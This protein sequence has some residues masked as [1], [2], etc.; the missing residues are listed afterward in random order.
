MRT[1][2]NYYTIGIFVTIG[3][4]LVLGF[5][6]ILGAGAI[7][8][9]RVLIETYV[10][11]SI[12]GI[13]VGSHVKM[14]GV[15]IGNVEH[16][17]FVNIKYPEALLTEKR[18]VLLEISL[19]LKAFGDVTPEELET[20]LEQEAKK[21]LRVRML[22]MGITGS[23][24]IEIDYL[25]PVR[26]PPLP[27]NWSPENTYVPSA[28]GTFTRLEETFESLSNTMAKLE[29]VDFRSTLD[30]LD[31]LIVSLTATVKSLDLDHMTTQANLFMDE[32][33]ETNLRISGILGPSSQ[34]MAQDIN[35]YNILSDTSHVMGD[36]R[37]GFERLGMDQEDGTLDQLFQTIANLSQA[38]EDLPRTM[39]SIR[40]AAD[41]M[42]QGSAG[43]N[44]MTRRAHSLMA[45]Q[46]Q[47]IEAI[48]RDMEVTTRNL[49]D[50]TTDA[51]RYPSY[52]L[53]GD[54]P[55]ESDPR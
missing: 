18:Y 14:R 34:Q 36:I 15:Q 21:G 19:S 28:P 39:Q 50:L 49:M 1:S 20:F 42:H 12:Q 52:F 9:E 11:E 45:S 35:I 23:S 4:I 3:L 43:F 24:Y 51:R 53:F 55:L 22:P 29:Q 33:R 37:K 13:D 6:I 25:D 27:I 10:D 46:N 30:H 8:R 44:R 40:E 5:L 32:L 7:W 31:E 38:T 41:A 16:I 47:K 17:S 2:P 54:K 26:H 48:L